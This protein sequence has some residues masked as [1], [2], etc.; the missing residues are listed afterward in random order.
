V[1]FND[2]KEDVMAKWKVTR[3]PA[4]SDQPHETQTY[5]ADKAALDPSENLELTDEHGPV[6]V[7]SRGHWI[8]YVRVGR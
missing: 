8:E 2:V 3:R 7:F 6:A 4:F 5:D 1:T